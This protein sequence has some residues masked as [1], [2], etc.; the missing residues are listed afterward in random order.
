MTGYQHA[1]AREARD[2]TERQTQGLG[3]FDFPVRPPA[4]DESR[5]LPLAGT[6]EGAY[7]AW[8]ATA[9]G[10]WLFD[11]MRWRALALVRAGESRVGTKALVEW[12]RA[13]HKATINNDFTALIARELLE[14]EA[15]LH[16]AIECRQ[17]SA[18]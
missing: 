3:L 2:R 11:V 13:Q 10:S 8:R 18:A 4:T 9:E 16:G 6:I 12:A 7:Q 17:R 1:L 15:E 5:V 14:N